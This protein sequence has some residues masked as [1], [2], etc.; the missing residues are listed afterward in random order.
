VIENLLIERKPVKHARIRVND[1]Q[2][3]RVIVPEDFN[4]KEMDL[5]LK[6][7]QLWITRHLSYFKRKGKKIGLRRNQLLL[8][9]ER[10]TYYYYENKGNL[11][12]VNRVHRTIQAK[13]DLFDFQIQIR[14]Y[15]REARKFIK[16]Q[17]NAISKKYKLP[18]K[19][20][21]IRDQRSKWGNCSS[22]RNISVN[23]RLI[24]APIDVIDYIL[25]H[26]LLHTKI[27]K[28]SQNFWTRMS[29]LCP[30]YRKSIKWLENYG[31]SL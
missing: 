1:K 11:V 5:L 21:F 29:V 19:K 18:Y 25:I 28:H 23:W 9:G 31:K 16:K 30:N 24:K 8:L 13:K 17:L 10:Y 4:K 6:K 27:M 2:Q 3:I 26:E 7:K 15:K 22:K 14:W 20:L 12:E